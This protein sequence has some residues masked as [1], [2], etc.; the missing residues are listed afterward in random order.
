MVKNLK[1]SAKNL[2]LKMDQY[3]FD[4]IISAIDDI[5]NIHEISSQIIV[6]D[7]PK[8]FK[9]QEIWK[10]Y[11]SPVS[12]QGTCGS[13]WAWATATCLSNRLKLK[14]LNRLHPELSAVFIL[15]CDIS[16]C[17]GVGKD[18]ECLT[19]EG[20]E[21]DLG[22]INIFY[23]DGILQKGCTGNTLENVWEF[24]YKFGTVE[25]SC[26]DYEISK[27]DE[28]KILPICSEMT[29]LKLDMCGNY[30][31]DEQ[32]LKEEGIPS[33][34]FRSIACYQ[35]PGTEKQGGSD[36][37]I[38]SDIYING[39]VTS[40]FVI[41]PDFYVQEWT[42]D[43]YEANPDQESLGGHA[44][45]II[46]WGEQDGKKFWWIENTWGKDWGANGYFKMIRGVNNC[47]IEEN[48]I[49][50]IPDLFYPRDFN[51]CDSYV[52][53]YTTMSNTLK[54]RRLDADFGNGMHGT[55]GFDTRTGFTRRAL[56][57]YTGFDFSPLISI[58]EI[59]MLLDTNKNV[60]DIKEKQIVEHFCYTRNKSS[61]SFPPEYI[62]LIIFGCLI[63]LIM[64]RLCYLAT[65]NKTKLKLENL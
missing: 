51:F 56:Q 52:S 12:F 17:K 62:M 11:L 14:T 20:S 32:N 59:E 24:L 1:L 54:L 36:L 47:G 16:F 9:G 26:V 64:I 37:N 44:V 5:K 43:I 63:F 3:R 15:L 25:K 27:V 57:T 42:E 8:N 33:R 13:C 60:G 2:K 39:P 19:L 61:N 23:A 38:M 34:F 41:Y 53:N 31:Y 10:D 28:E 21:F 22:K 49:C 4:T 65:N 29:G 45:N 55:S 40:G 48:V 50:G 18:K 35:V 6:K 30:I 46:G 58:M 7:L